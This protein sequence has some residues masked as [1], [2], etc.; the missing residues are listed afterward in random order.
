MQKVSVSI[1]SINLGRVVSVLL[2]KKI[3]LNV[4]KGLLILSIDVQPSRI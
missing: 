4:P 1:V 3:V 2:N